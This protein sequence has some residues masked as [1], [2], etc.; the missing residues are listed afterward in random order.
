VESV[1]LTTGEEAPAELRECLTEA[2]YT[3][4]LGPTDTDFD[5][6]IK[7]MLG[8]QRLS[9]EDFGDG[10]TMIMPSGGKLAD[11]MHHAEITLPP[12]GELEFDEETAAQIAKLL[13]E[14]GEGEVSM[15]SVETSMDVESDG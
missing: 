7:L 12:G 14:H 6:E 3:L 9:A 5:Q 1:E 10:I 15:L 2:M 11:Q 4:D 13:G 8:H